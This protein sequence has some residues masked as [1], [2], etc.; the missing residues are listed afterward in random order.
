MSEEKQGKGFQK[1]R[2]KTG[3]RTKGTPNK[4]TSEFAELVKEFGT[5]EK[6][7]KLYNRTSKEEIKLA[8]LKEFLKY[9]YPQRKAVDV[10]ADNIELPVINIEG[11]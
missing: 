4:K 11:I 9:Q 8:I 6:M 3:G 7:I 1:G 2:I 10:K 5:V